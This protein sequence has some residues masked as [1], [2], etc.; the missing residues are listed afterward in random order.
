[1]FNE[2]YRMLFIIS[3]CLL[4]LGV[5]V[6]LAFQDPKWAIIGALTAGMGANLLA[7]TWIQH[8]AST[9]QSTLLR[10][11]T[12]SVEGVETLPESFRHLTWTAYSTRIAA[13]QGKKVEWLFAPMQKVYVRGTRLAQYRFLAR[14]PDAQPA[15]YSL[16]FLGLKGCVAGF[17]AKEHG[18]GE[19]VSVVV[20]DVPVGDVGVHFGVGYLTDW[21]GERA[22]SIEI[23]GVN[24][25]P[26]SLKELPTGVID[27][28]TRW[29]E[30]VDWSVANTKP[31]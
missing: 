10:E 11:L 13:G 6:S 15:L 30:K 7:S 16:T 18:G 1:M 25:I 27:R 29:H 21:L 9:E 28:L 5:I 8:F 12:L 17:T 22:L 26:T 2:I 3:V 31:F 14:T 20:Y 19:T 4:L 24:P 23:V